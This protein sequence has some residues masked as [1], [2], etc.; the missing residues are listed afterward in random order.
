MEYVDITVKFASHQTQTTN[1]MPHTP[2]EWEVAARVWI[3]GR[4]GKAPKAIFKIPK[5]VNEMSG[6]KFQLTTIN[7]NS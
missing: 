7:K 6:G 5:A 4:N 1:R 3:T 2:I